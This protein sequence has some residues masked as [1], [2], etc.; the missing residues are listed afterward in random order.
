MAVVHVELDIDGDVYPELYAV[1]AALRQ[2]MLRDERMRQLAAM[3]LAWEAVRLHGA[4]V[5]QVPARGTGF[6]ATANSNS[7]SM[8]PPA[9]REQAL[10]AP[11]ALVSA[12]APRSTSRTT[13]KSTSRKTTSRSGS[14]GQPQLPVLVDIVA[15]R[16]E[17]MEAAGASAAD[18]G[19]DPPVDPM[20]V[21][22]ASRGSGA[23]TRLMRMKDRGLFKNG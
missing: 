20:P 8:S 22:A 18:D 3:G 19:P 2:P 9:V 21:T 10:P 1:L 5:T 15:T 6:T 23:R 13:P 7:S 14:S 12:P 11:A 16:Q 4:V 17:E